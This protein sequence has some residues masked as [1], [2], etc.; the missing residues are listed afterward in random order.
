MT[1]REPCHN[2]R[3]S[4]SAGYWLQVRDYTFM[5][6]YAMR[7]K[8]IPHTMT[9]ECQQ[10]GRGHDPLPGCEGCNHLQRYDDA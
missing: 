1:Y 10:P 3:T 4:P 2:N 5:G 8:F 7:N 6:T 9:R